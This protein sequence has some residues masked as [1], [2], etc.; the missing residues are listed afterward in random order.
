MDRWIRIDN[1]SI[2][3]DINIHY[4]SR[5]RAMGSRGKTK[6]PE[7]DV[8]ALLVLFPVYSYLLTFAGAMSE[9]KLTIC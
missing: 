5:K 3:T 6:S 9:A 4:R 2:N 7:T 8:A 1:T